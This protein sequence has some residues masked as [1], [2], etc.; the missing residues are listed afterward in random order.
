MTK[1][2]L[3]VKNLSVEFNVRGQAVK[4]VREVSWNV[5]KGER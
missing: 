4:A 5:K 3:E 2:A 1:L